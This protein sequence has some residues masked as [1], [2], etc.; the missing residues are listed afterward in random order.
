MHYSPP[1]LIQRAPDHAPSVE[2]P[3]G[4]KKGN[5]SYKKAAKDKGPII[6]NKL[7]MVEEYQ[8]NITE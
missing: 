1:K 8:P 4:E 5:T 6:E 7:Q 3:S 2:K